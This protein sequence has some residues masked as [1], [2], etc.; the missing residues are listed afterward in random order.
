MN[1]LL[2]SHVE[3]SVSCIYT[4]TTYRKNYGT[5]TPD[6]IISQLEF[7]PVFYINS[8]TSGI[9]N[10][11]HN[12]RYSKVNMILLFHIIAVTIN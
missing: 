12:K 8:P 11:T 2:H 3:R 6:T 10:V 9:F 4:C 5:L 1:H 7:Q